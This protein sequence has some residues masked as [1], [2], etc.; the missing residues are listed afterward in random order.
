MLVVGV[1]RKMTNQT[2]EPGSIKKSGQ[3]IDLRIVTAEAVPRP[4]WTNKYRYEVLLDGPNH[5][6]V[7]FIYW[8]E[9]L[10]EGHHYKVRVNEDHGYPQIDECI[11]ELER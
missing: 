6:K 10:R 9:Y 3:E 1:R 8:S 2:V 11:E 5:G 4:H 7:D